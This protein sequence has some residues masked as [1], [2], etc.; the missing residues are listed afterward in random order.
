MIMPFS[1]LFDQP[2]VPSAPGLL[3][4]KVLYFMLR[5]LR[6]PPARFVFS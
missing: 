3:G 2:L 1:M 6:V 4:I 5:Y